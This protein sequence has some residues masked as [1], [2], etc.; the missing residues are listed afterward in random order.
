LL[1]FEEIIDKTSA[2]RKEHD[3]GVMTL[4]GA[5]EDGPA[6]DDRPQIPDTEFDKSK[7]L[8]FE[9]EMLGLY[10]SDHPLMGLESALRRKTEQ[11][12]SDLE[13]LEDGAPVTI[14]GGVT[15]LQRKWTKKGDLMGIFI[16]EDLA[17]SAECM[18]FPRTFTDYGHLLDDDRVVIARARVQKRDDEAKLMIQSIEVFE[19]GNLGADAPV[20]LEVRPDQLSDHMIE[21]LKRVLT[22]YPGESSVYIHLSD[23][24]VIK[25]ADEFN[26]YRHAGSQNISIARNTGLDAA[27]Q[28]GDWVAM[29]DDDIMV[30]EDWFIAHLD[31]QERTGADATTGPLLLQFPEDA[32]SWIHDEPFDRFGL[33]DF[34][35]DENVPICATGNSMLRAAFLLEHDDIRFDPELGVLGGEDMVFY[36]AAVGRGLKCYFST[37]T[38]VFEV[39]PHDRSTLKYQLGRAMWMGNTQYLTNHRSGDA[40]GNRLFL[41][42]GRQV[43]R[44]LVRP[45][46][47][48]LNREAP[49]LRFAAALVCEGVGMMAGR[50]GVELDHHEP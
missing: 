3:M 46:T 40:T 33:L 50:F 32:A 47:R 18:V 23:T 17:A 21:D 34:G 48:L 25:L 29:T 24:Q 41:R 1:T 39:E 14:G 12:L 27:S 6:Y 11:S 35:E 45:V 36:R 49:Q 4:F 19:A 13:S 20:R 2:T 8:A 31:L 15:Q 9:K 44:A 26:H 38:A 16:L 30:P 42:G 37:K 7:R 22:E 28:I 10:V 5:S 43:A